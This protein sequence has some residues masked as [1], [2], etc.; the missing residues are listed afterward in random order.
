MLRCLSLLGLLALPVHAGEVVNDEQVAA[1]LADNDGQVARCAGVIEAPCAHHKANGLLRACMFRLRERW[2]RQVAIGEAPAPTGE[3]LAEACPREGTEPVSVS[4]N[5]NRC[6]I[7]ILAARW[8]A[9]GE[10]RDHQ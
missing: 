1:C 7:G 5:R 8:I 10:G 6:R 2:E 3:E 4:I 9:A